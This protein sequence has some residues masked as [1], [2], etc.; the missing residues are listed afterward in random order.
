MKT[1]LVPTDFSPASRKTAEYAAILAKPLGAELFLLHTYTDPV[2]AVDG[3]TPIVTIGIEFREECQVQIRK[4]I[5][6]L[7]AKYRVRAKGEAVM[8]FKGDTIKE[9]A[10]ELG[11]GLICVGRKTRKHKPL[12]GTTALKTV[13]KTDIPVIIVPDDAVLNP[14]K[15]IVLAIDYKEMLHQDCMAPLFDLIK[16][17]NASLTVLHVEKAGAEISPGEVPEKLQ[18]GRVLSRITYLHQK[19]ENENVE[20]GILKF[21]STDPTDLLVMIAHRHNLFARIFGDVHTSPVAFAITVPLL[22]LKNEAKQTGKK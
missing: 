4:E 9:K 7:K 10:E 19:L 17:N 1:I 20:D 5:K 12:F 8:G 15:R 16:V 14:P 22:I 18:L 6:H 21:I 2:P 13:R 11:A 3:S